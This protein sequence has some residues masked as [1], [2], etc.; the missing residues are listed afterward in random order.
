MTKGNYSKGIWGNFVGFSSPKRREKEKKEKK[1]SKKR[2]RQDC[3]LF[4]RA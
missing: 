2:E 4:R 3:H 1:R